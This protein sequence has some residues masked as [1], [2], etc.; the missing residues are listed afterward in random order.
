MNGA[1]QLEGAGGGGVSDIEVDNIA[2]RNELVSQGSITD[3][4]VVFVKDASADANVKSGWATYQ[5]HEDSDPAEWVKI[6]DQE[7]RDEVFITDMDDAVTMTK[8]I[9]NF[10]AGTSVADVKGMSHNKVIEE[11]LFETD[12]YD[13]VNPLL[14]LNSGLFIKEVGELFNVNVTALFTKND[15][16]D[17]TEVRFKKDGST[18]QT[19][20]T[21]PLDYSYSDLNVVLVDGE[22]NQYLAEVD[23]A[24]GDVVNDLT[25]KGLPSP[26][27]IV[28]GTL[29]SALRRESAK[30]KIFYGKS[31]GSRPLTSGAIR[32][33]SSQFETDLTLTLEMANGE[34]NFFLS[35]PSHLSI[36]DVIFKGAFTGTIKADVIATESIVKVEG[37]SAGSVT[38]VANQAA[39]LA[40]PAG[41]GDMADRSDDG[42]TYVLTAADAT[43]VANWKVHSD[44]NKTYFVQ[45]A[46]PFT[47]SEIDITLVSA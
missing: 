12:W 7:G 23:Y 32:A 27:P 8:A 24:N 17:L 40:L 16:G 30:R 43:N 22:E 29:I 10:P 15:A 9:G 35:I 42:K 31:L 1:G 5:W 41:I 46:S 11:L 47:A 19:D 34:T 28:A 45:P 33:L 44:N 37:A 36:G 25:G 26:N 18:V 21:D 14:G 13:Y 2:Q 3:L 6:Q 38:T 4:Q 20:N 39:M